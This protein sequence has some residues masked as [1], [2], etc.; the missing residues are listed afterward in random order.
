MIWLFLFF[1]AFCFVVWRAPGEVMQVALAGA[2][3]LLAGSIVWALV[4]GLFGAT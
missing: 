2:W 3:V 4:E 1:A